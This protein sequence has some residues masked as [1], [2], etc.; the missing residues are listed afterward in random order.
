LVVVTVVVIGSASP[1]RA[2][3]FQWEYITP[4]DPS[5]GKRQ[6]TTLAPDGAGVDAVPGVN[7]SRNLAKAYLVG[8]DLTG[9]YGILAY[10]AEADLSYANLTNAYLGGVTLTGAN[11]SHANLTDA[12]FGQ[13]TGGEYPPATG[14]AGFDG[15]SLAYANLRGARFVGAAFTDTDF[16]GADIQGANFAKD[17]FIS[18]LPGG[19]L[20]RG[21]I[22]SA[23]LYA[24]ASHQNHDLSG[25]NLA[26]NQFASGNFAEQNLTGA[27]FA[28]AVLTEADFGYAD[29]SK[30]NFAN[31]RLTGADFAHAHVRGANFGNTTSTGFTLEQLYS[32][33]SYLAKDLS[34]IDLGQNNL[35]SANFVGQSI[36][37]GDF[38]DATLTDAEFRGANLNGATFDGAALT[39]ADF[40]D[41]DVRGA[42]FL[43]HG[44]GTGLSLAQIYST[45]SYQDKDLSG[46]YLN[47]HDLSG[48]DFA[49]QNV[50]NARF[51]YATL[52]DANFTDADVRGADFGGSE[53]TPAQLYST[54]SYKAKDLSGTDL[55]SQSL[56]A[57]NF[58]GQNLANASFS[59]LYEDSPDFTAADARG[60]SGL[61]FVDLTG[62][63]I[64][65]LI[66]Y[67]GYITGL[68][69]NL[70][71]L[72]MVRDYD[73]NPRD[74][75]GNALPPIPITV[76]QHLSIGPTGTLRM[77]F[78]ADAWDSTISFAPGIPVTLGGTLELTFAADVNPATQLG[79][80]FD[81]FNWTGVAPTG[82]FAI[83]SPYRW[84]LSNLYATGQVTLTALPEPATFILVIVAAI[85]I[86]R[87]GGRTRQELV[88]A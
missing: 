29:L 43:I 35:S 73:G 50:T 55:R 69:L 30:A 45:A 82:A 21:G 52:T 1:A 14:W 26:F 20:R 75:Y 16:T 77:V 9:A 37:N 36:A 51:Y 39:N 23:Q 59:F 12:Y 86:R 56:N 11:L 58:A 72:L 79:R 83:S 31:A 53:L 3:I 81:L 68:D 8:S 57:A 62:A 34:G 25:I 85:S 6:S 5:Q 13:G 49:G 87:I 80:T 65:N 78:E 32:T 38:S 33:A 15:A 44:P 66:R 46:V 76:D 64:A 28:G 7:L 74:I 42:R 71:G 22:S 24:T 67:D 17:V 4:A 70:G 60:A 2:D 54:A 18:G 27:I 63:T 48:G 88:P 19:P 61:G 41:A 84:N 40:T 10:L 47:G